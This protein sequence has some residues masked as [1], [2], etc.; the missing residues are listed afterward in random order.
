MKN[1]KIALKVTIE[2][3]GYF[4]V[5]DNVSYD[6][7]VGYSLEEALSDYATTIK[8]RLE[9]ASECG[10]EL[11]NGKLA[12]LRRMLTNFENGADKVSGQR[13]TNCHG[14]TKRGSITLQL[15]WRPNT[16]VVN[17]LTHDNLTV[18]GVW[19]HGRECRM[20]PVIKVDR[21]NETAPN[22]LRRIRGKMVGANLRTLSAEHRASQSE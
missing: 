7:G 22:I 11:Y 21:S 6:Y 16:Q 5:S 18:E 10:N 1:D 15:H 3:Q 9:I 13:V 17:V 20:L 14:L 12:P 8:E 19:E 4:V 2:N